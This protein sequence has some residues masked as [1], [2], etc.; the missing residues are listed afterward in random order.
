MFFTLLGRRW[1]GLEH[2]EQRVLCRRQAAY[3]FRR[4]I[5]YELLAAVSGFRR[6]MQ[7]SPVPVAWK[8]GAVA[9]AGDAGPAMAELGSGELGSGGGIGEWRIALNAGRL[10]PDS[11][12]R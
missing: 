5:R 1:E 3:C 7:R 12:E 2:G 10:A 6:I 11:H 9:Y 8:S 4:W